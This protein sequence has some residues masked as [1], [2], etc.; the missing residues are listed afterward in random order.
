M[1]ASKSDA[2]RG[3][4]LRR[5]LLLGSLLLT[6]LLVCYRAFALQVLGADAWRARARNQQAN[7]VSLPA[8]RGTIYDREG[9]PL[10]ASQEA[11]RISIAPRELE[12]PAEV[13]RLLRKHAGLSRAA[14]QRAVDRSRRWIVLPGRYDVTAR[15]GLNGVYG[16]YFERTLRRFQPRGEIASELLGLV[17]S[18]NRALGGLEQEFDA[19]L[20]GQPGR[21][22]TRRDARGRPI[23]GAL[24]EVVEP[25]PGHDLHLTIDAELQEIAREALAEAIAETRAAGG[26]LLL[27]DPRTGEVLAAVSSKEGTSSWRAVTE[28]Y[29]P[30]STLKPFAVATLLAEKRTYLSES[31][32]AENGAYTRESRTIRD[33]TAHGW[34]TVAQA[35]SHSSNIVL[36]KLSERLD[37]TTQYAYLRA[38][39]FGSPTAVTYPSE[40]S[41]LLRRPANWSRFSPASLAIGYEISVTPLQL[42]M[43]WGALANG[44]VLMEPRLVREVR[45]R[46]GRTM[47]T[48]PPQAVRRVIPERIAN[49]LRPALS[50]VV[51]GGTAR[52]AAL[53]PWDVAGK[54]GT[55]RTAVHGRYQNGVY[56]SS[57][58]GFFPASD[59]QLVF[60]VKLDSPRG[61]YYGGVTAAPVTRTLLE[62]AL[63]ARS[64]PLDKRSVATKAPPPLDR[65]QV[66]APRIVKPASGPFI[67]A[68]DA[69]TS[70]RPTP[71]RESALASVPDVRGLALRDA[72]RHLH[73]RG[74][75]V[76]LTGRGVISA[77]EPRAGAIVPRGAL[78]RVT[79]V[80]LGS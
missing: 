51:K 25:V 45:T 15:Q 59:P 75:R 7:Q 24:Q 5:R 18:D 52:T 63:A 72:V 9:V 28:P 77:S 74:L 57:F 69:G 8:P 70:R 43:A 80:G 22:V 66:R 11:F 49:Q 42:L 46:E 29:E 26:E 55:V 2:L 34:L 78:V 3:L 33:E 67:F 48:L 54:T 12:Q 17:S 58:A 62:A 36:A 50:D 40:S 68:L 6:S 73:A 38:F 79:A 19:E 16:V 10:A 60:L 56:T 35:L 47:R 71:A 32:F 27:S 41:G 61:E 31:V 21:A 20:R 76:R 23:P 39:G 44:G 53:G 37:P 4:A 13:A 64:T 1:R 30:G 65:A 14:A